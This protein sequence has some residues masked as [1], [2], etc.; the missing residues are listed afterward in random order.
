MV[1]K[2]FLCLTWCCRGGTVNINKKG[3]PKSDIKTRCYVVVEVDHVH[4]EPESKRKA[5]EKWWSHGSGVCL[6]PWWV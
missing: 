2:R 5:V 4:I 6:I 3:A 1:V